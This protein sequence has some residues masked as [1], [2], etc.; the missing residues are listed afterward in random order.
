MLIV[1]RSGVSPII[2]TII[3]ILIAMVAGVLLWVWVSGYV[4]GAPGVRP[5][6]EERIKIE[7]VSLQAGSIKIYVRN[8][9]DVQVNVS[10]GYI[11]DINGNYVLG[12]PIDGVRIR[13]GEVKD[14]VILR[15]GSLI[16][17]NIYVAKIV[18]Q[19]GTEALYSF[20]YAHS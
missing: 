4:S 14:V 12:G 11:L 19:R 8:V 6:L 1:L 15:D 5:A 17:N 10:S 3:L 13:P 16:P 7:A 9:G 2:A 18:T 20:V